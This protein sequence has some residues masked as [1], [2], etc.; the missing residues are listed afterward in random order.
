M[1][2]A[3]RYYSFT[4]YVNI[5]VARRRARGAVAGRDGRRWWRRY[6]ADPS[7]DAAGREQVVLDQCQF[8]DGR[9][10]ERVVQLRARRAGRRAARA[11]RHEDLP[12]RARAAARAADQGRRD[13]A[14]DSRRGGAA[15][16][17]RPRGARHVARSR[18]RRASDDDR[19][20]PLSLRARFRRRSIADCRGGDAARAVALRRRRGAC[21]RAIA[22][23]I[24]H[25]HSRPAGLWLSR[26]AR[27][28]AHAGDLAAQH[29]IRLGVRLSRLGSAAVQRGLRR[30]PRACCACR[31]SSARTPIERYPRIVRRRRDGLQRRRRRHVSRR[32]R[33]RRRRTPQ[34]D[35]VCRPRRRA[36]RRSR[37]ARCLRAGDRRARAARAAAHRRPAFVLGRAAVA[38]ITTRSRSAA[39]PTRASSC[40]A[41]PT[42]IAELAA[43]YR[44][45]RVQRGA[46]GVSRSAGPDVARS[47]GVRRAGGGLGRRRTCRRRCRLAR[48]ASCSRTATPSQLARS[49]RCRSSTIPIGAARWARPRASGRWRRS[50]GT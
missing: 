32:P 30:R 46:V 16:G 33:P 39:Q 10:A 27:R 42:T 31:T 47:A 2:S 25:H 44:E 29:G 26:A 12:C 24:V 8:T 3:R 40:A 14:V 13:R 28:R 7:L 43:I 15:G 19:R 18:R 37:A 35:S 23:D 41:R 50:R 20:R 1:K 49:G 17:A 9:S 38:A 6:L 45:P 34:T 22:P 21:S 48:A 36:Q 4:H 11:R 5:T